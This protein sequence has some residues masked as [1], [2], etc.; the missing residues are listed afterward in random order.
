MAVLFTTSLQLAPL[1]ISTRRVVSFIFSDRYTPIEVESARTNELYP[2]GAAALYAA[3]VPST[4]SYN[5]PLRNTYDSLRQQQQQ[6]SLS[7]HAA[8]TSTLYDSPN[9]TGAQQ[10]ARKRAID[11]RQAATNTEARSL[12]EEEFLQRS[13]EEVVETNRNRTIGKRN[14]KNAES[15]DMEEDAMDIDTGVLDERRSSKRGAIDGEEEEAERTKRSKV[16]SSIDLGYD[17]DEYNSD[18]SSLP[19]VTIP[20]RIKKRRD[21]SSTRSSSQEPVGKRQSSGRGSSKR[22]IDDVDSA[23]GEDDDDDTA[24]GPRNADSDFDSEDEQTEED[25]EETEEDRGRRRV[26]ERRE[27]KRAKSLGRSKREER[28]E[29]DAME[30]SFEDLEGRSTLPSPPTSKAVAPSRSSLSN[31]AKRSASLIPIKIKRKIGEEWKNADGDK[32]K[33][34][35]D[36]IPR[37]LSEVREMRKK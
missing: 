18:A 20:K 22:D 28:E 21:Q 24:G 23:S 7:R 19:D 32:F 35:E 6:T 25:E 12:E 29:S 10:S 31:K 3:A 27:G 26:K 34:G 5:S 4:S 15:M 8:F 16:S 33:L 36:N 2:T 11:Q 9:S 14:K 30:G 13:A 1:V 17:D 37:K